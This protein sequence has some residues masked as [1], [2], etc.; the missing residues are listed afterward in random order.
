MIAKRLL[1]KR[2]T[3]EE[4]ENAK[5]DPFDF[6][7]AVLLTDP[8]TIRFANGHPDIQLTQDEGENVSDYQE[9]EIRRVSDKLVVRICGVAWSGK[10]SQPIKASKAKTVGPRREWL[11]II[12]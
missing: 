1:L 4:F 12:V 10:C 9:I 6:C 5:T 7:N 3:R 8:P 11:N 2:G